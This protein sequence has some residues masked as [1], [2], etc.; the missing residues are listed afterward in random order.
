MFWEQGSGDSEMGN[1]SNRQIYWNSLEVGKT[2]TH[3]P[4]YISNPFIK[5]KWKYRGWHSEQSCLRFLKR[6]GNAQIFTVPDL[7]QGALCWWFPPFGEFVMHALNVF[8]LLRWAVGTRRD[9]HKNISPQVLMA[10][11]DAEPADEDAAVFF[12]DRCEVTVR[13]RS[14]ALNREIIRIVHIYLCNRGGLCV[15]VKLN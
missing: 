6:G 13:W 10:G 1:T 12:F 11:N 4:S 7:L 5:Y 3:F 15:I 9:F 2:W 8:G 14:G